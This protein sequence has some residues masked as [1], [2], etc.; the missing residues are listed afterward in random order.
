M[1]T[2]SIAAVV[3]AAGASRRLGEPKQ[4]LRVNGESLLRHSVRVA[5]EAGCSPVIVVLGAHA[6]RLLPELAGLQTSIIH[7]SDWQQG[8]SSSVRAGVSAAKQAEDVLLLVCDQ[9]GI[10][11]AALH[12]LITAHIHAGSPITASSYGSTLGVP[13]IFAA[14]LFNDLLRLEGD[15]GAR[16]VIA[17][18]RDHITIVN[19]PEGAFDVDTPEDAK[20]LKHLRP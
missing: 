4:L 13:A 8:M 15:Q 11:A 17:A 18:H 19:F 16:K 10:S 14:S 9:P 6:E 3:L 20:R 2:P 1:P 12:H 7:N 5:I